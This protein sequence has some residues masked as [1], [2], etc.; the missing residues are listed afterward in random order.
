MIPPFAS[1]RTSIAVLPDSQIPSY[2]D[3]MPQSRA[4]GPNTPQ[5]RRPKL[6]R[7]TATAP[8]LATSNASRKDLANLQ[9]SRATTLLARMASNS[10]SQSDQNLQSSPHSTCS[11]PGMR[12]PSPADSPFGTRKEPFDLSIHQCKSCL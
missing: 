9:P 2:Y 1:F 5:T 12:S 3:K 8:A 4:T 10:R 11:S 6:M 7:A